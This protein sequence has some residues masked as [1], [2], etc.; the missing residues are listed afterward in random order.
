MN[1]REMLL[2]MLNAALGLAAT[3]A[4]GNTSALR[5]PKL[6]CRPVISGALWWLDPNESAKWG[7]SGWRDELD[8]QRRIGF[9]LLWLLNTMSA[10]DHPDDPLGRLMDLC[11]KRK[12][13]VILDTGNA[14]GVWYNN[15]DPKRELE[16]CGKHIKRLAERFS[17]H[18]AF[19]A[20]Y[21]PH[22]IY[23]CWG[24]WASKI[25]VL[26]SGLTDL[27]K[28]AADVPVT[29]S[30]FFI[31]DRDKVFGDFRFNEPDEYRDYWAR[32]IRKSGIDVIMLQDSGEHFSYVT[33]EQREPFFE[34]MRDACRLGGARLWGNV[35]TA[36][37]ECPSIK[38]YVRRY[39]RMHHST[40]KDAPWR[41][42]PIARLKEKLELA[43]RSSERIVTWGYRE[44]CRPSLGARAAQWYE[45][46]RRY[47]RSVM[48][49]PRDT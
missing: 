17:G 7:V 14:P 19:Y 48:R 16:A 9:D 47:A 29:L 34:A 49:D 35:E 44:F 10:M 36:E 3:S 31:L 43:A 46:Y 4:L 32:L 38:E 26:Y 33:M 21:I 1:R 45:E 22:E 8:R 20:W 12:V 27:C 6:R 41:P 30:P 11:G 37:F 5:P 15:F 18:P 28:K 40:V 25:E 2:H 24:D 13:Q 23:M 39:G 42:V